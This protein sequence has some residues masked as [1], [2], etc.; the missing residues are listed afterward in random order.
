VK[1]SRGFDFTKTAFDLHLTSM[2]KRYGLQAIVN[3]LG[4]SMIGSKEGEAMLS[5]EF[6]RQHN[7]SRHLDVPMIVFDYHQE[8]RGAGISTA[9]NKLKNQMEKICPDFGIFLL[10]GDDAK[11]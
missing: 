8:C 10:D 1:L 6:Q 9:L 3:L 11:Q 4:T 2:K 5:N 7:A